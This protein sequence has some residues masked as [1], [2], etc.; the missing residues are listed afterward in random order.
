MTARKLMRLDRLV[1][2]WAQPV[3]GPPRGFGLPLVA[4][5]CVFFSKVLPLSLPQGHSDSEV[6]GWSQGEL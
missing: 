2:L 3:Q 4:W 6:T 5:A 1:P